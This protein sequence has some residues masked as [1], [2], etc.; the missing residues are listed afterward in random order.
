MSNSE[1]ANCK[2]QKYVINSIKFKF[3]N[4]EGFI[5]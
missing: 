2:M 5:K 1:W 3:D 4:W